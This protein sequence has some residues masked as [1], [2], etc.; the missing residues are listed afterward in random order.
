MNRI[1]KLS[2]L[3]TA[4]GLFS[5]ASANAELIIDDSDNPA[6]TLSKPATTLAPVQAPVSKPTGGFF[7]SNVSST[8]S[9]TVV[10]SSTSVLSS[11][12]T[13]TGTPIISAPLKGWGKD[14]PLSTALK[15]V[16][17]DGW[18]AKKM[19]SVDL[20][21]K[22]NW[23]GNKPWVNVL[24][25]LAVQNGFKANVDWN[26]KTLTI[27]STNSFENKVANPVVSSVSTTSRPVFSGTS[28]SSTGSVSPSYSYSSGRT[29]QLVSTKTLKENIQ[30]W[31]NDAGWTL[32]WAAP[33]YPIVGNMTLTGQIDA[34]DG[35][36]ARVVAAYA[37]AK[38]PLRASINEGNK[39]IRIESR[40]Y[41]QETVVQSPVDQNYSSMKVN[42]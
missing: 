16:V 2:I 39:V 22:V 37:K 33:D 30:Q 6:E 36:I 13:Q 28:V 1:H 35:P 38:Q 40:N 14:I 12:V 15:Q 17:P 31:A 26:S 5:I 11:N 3:I 20:N 19:G 24:D 8:Q 25:D 29:W 27:S 10:T 21:K 42:Q 32:S 18:K 9:A 41:N 34:A 23:N 7:N 4:M